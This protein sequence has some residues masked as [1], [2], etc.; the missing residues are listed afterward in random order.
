MS[1][2]SSLN[3]AELEALA[4]RV[5][6]LNPQ[7]AAQLYA[8]LTREVNAECAKDGLKWMRFASTRDESDPQHSVKIFPSHLGYVREV[9]GILTTRPKVA[10]AKSRQMRMSW[11]LALF[12]CWQARY[13]PN[14][15]IYWQTKNW[16][17]AVGMVCMPQGGVEGRCQFIESHLPP[18]L[19]LDVKPSEGRIQ[20]PNGSLIQALSGGADKIRGKVASVIIEDEFAFQEDQE[21]VYAAVAPLVQNGARAIFV[22]TPNGTDNQFAT[23]WHGR[24]VSQA[25]RGE[26]G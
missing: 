10:I 2:L 9:W 25:R 12:A 1:L 4:A 24:N 16:E 19:R 15:A 17:D 6:G 23:L 11:L 7:Q 8:S 13:Y 26:V 22:S 18:F 5:D 14:Q 20:Y 21:G 3:S